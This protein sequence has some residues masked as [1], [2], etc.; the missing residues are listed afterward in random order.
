MSLNLPTKSSLL[1]S[2]FLFFAIVPGAM[3]QRYDVTG[4]VVDSEGLA[5]RGATVVIVTVSDST[6]VSFGTTR[7]EGDFQLRRVPSGKYV[8]KVSFVG[9][10]THVQDIDV[11]DGDADAGQIALLDSVTELGELVVTDERI[12]IIVKADTVVYDASAFKV[13]AYANVEELLKRLPGIEVDRDGTI[14]AQGEEVEQILVD[15]KEFFGDDPKIA[16][17]NLQAEAVEKVEVFDKKSDIAEFTG[18]DD[19]EE[20]KTINLEL[21]DDFRQGY[22]GSLSGAYGMDNHYDGSANVNRFSPTTQLALIGNATDVSGQRFSSG[23]VA[24]IGGSRGGG[25]FAQVGGGSGLTTAASGGIN[26]SHDIKKSTRLRSSYFLNYADNLV[27]SDILQQQLVNGRDGALTVQNGSDESESLNH[28][29]NVDVEHDFNAIST[30]RVRVRGQASQTESLDAQSADVT[31]ND[32]LTQSVT[33]IDANGDRIGGNASATYMHR[34]GGS[35]RNIVVDANASVN[36]TDSESDFESTTDFYRSGNLLT[37]EEISQLQ[38]NLSDNLTARAQVS[39]TE[40]LGG[41]KFLELRLQRRQVFETQ[42]QSVYDKVGDDILVF[43]DSLSS[44]YDRTYAYNQARAVLRWDGKDEDISIGASVQQSH[45][46]G[47]IVDFGVPIKKSYVHLLPFATY[48]SDLGRGRRLNVRYSANTRE[49]TIQQLQPIVDNT[50]PLRI[51]VGNPDLNP[52]YTHSLRGDFR[53]FDQFTFMSVYA[54]V[55]AS[56]TRNQIVS[57]R[58]VDEQFRQTITPVN[59]DGD[60]TINGVQ[61]FGTPIRRLGV[62]IDVSNNIVYGRSTEFVNSNE[63]DTNTIRDAVK[64]SIGNRNKE[65]IDVTF[66]GTL[67]FNVNQYSLNDELDQQYLNRTV[68]GELA[69]TPTE[70]WRFSTGLDATFYSEEVFGDGQDVVLWSAE[71]SRSILQNNRA[72]IVIQARDL[73]NQSV[74]INYTNSAGFVRESQI[75]SVGRYVLLKFVYNLSR[76]G[77]GGRGFGRPRF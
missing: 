44:G 65:K 50:N 63:N 41:I 61:S 8:L 19:G 16:T 58:S 37:N 36:D 23:D 42:N 7:R 75:R 15:G 73:L 11:L 29:L 47:E 20:Q 38:S 57:A 43:N 40:P 1:A 2:A 48:R 45:L 26:L 52:E 53:W 72:Q 25:G 74:G 69:F 4:V 28:R 67:T 10:Q 30:L 12:P 27:D 39:Y 59:V 24:A 66:G 56:Y 21:K 35:L 71:A 54:S 13:R 64:L 55:R 32:N 68:F 62:Q 18:V 3:G 70:A 17:K 5:L 77:G 31:G 51:F 33:R 9:Y 46:D 60:W 34:F 49:P 14:T 76:N 22:F 6:L